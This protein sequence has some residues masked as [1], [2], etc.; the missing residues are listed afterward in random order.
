[1]FSGVRAGWLF[2]KRGSEE[3]KGAKEA[4]LFSLVRMYTSRA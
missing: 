4:G 3:D 2:G 1:M